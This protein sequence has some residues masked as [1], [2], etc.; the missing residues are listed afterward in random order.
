MSDAAGG[1]IAAHY[2]VALD[3]SVVSGNAAI[4]PTSGGYGGGISAGSFQSKYSAVSANSVVSGFAGAGA[5]GGLMAYG[6]TGIY[7]ST[8]DHNIAA[9]GGAIRATGSMHMSNST[10]SQNSG[11][12]APLYVGSGISLT[13][14]I[15]NST[16][17]FNHADDPSR[18][19]G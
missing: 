12:Y 3:H 18:G 6:Q 8:F 15:A 1:G 2:E 7:H 16:I 4:A 10:I 19:G 11:R 14:E 17:A 5:G 9:F 13:A